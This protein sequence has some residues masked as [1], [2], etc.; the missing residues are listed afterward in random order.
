MN[1]LPLKDT[2]IDAAFAAGQII[3]SYMEEEIP[4]EEKEGGTNYASQVVTKV[5][6]ECEEMILSYLL[7]ACKEYDLALLTE[8][9]EDDGSRFEK[10]YFWCVDPIDGTLSFIKKEPG[11]SVSI[12]LVSR[13]GEPVIGVIYDPSTETLYH[14]AKGHGVYRND[15]PWEFPAPNDHLTHV[16]DKPL[17]NTSRPDDLKQLLQ[18]KVEELGVS[19]MRVIQGG[20]SVLNAINVLKNPPSCMIKHPKKETGGGSL[21]DF[22]STACLFHEL[23]CRATNFEGGQ[24]DLNRKDSTFMH[25]EGIYYECFRN[26]SIDP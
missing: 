12:A 22:A 2:A 13:E 4:I 19:G 11:F 20:G 24:L 5:D 15:K 8:E 25:H 17:E 18:E 9:T 26:R 6:K 14:G 21:W 23:G 1:L 3:R 7:P 16:T 10:E